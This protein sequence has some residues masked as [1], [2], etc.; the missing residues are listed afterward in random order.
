M[1]EMDQVLECKQLSAKGLGIRAISRRLGVSR[2]TVRAYLRGDRSPGIYRQE[3]RRPQ[4]V[5]DRLR[6]RVRQLL[7]EEQR[8]RTPRK[9]RL[10]GARIHRILESEDFLACPRLVRQLVQEVRMD[11]R[12][13]LQ[14][15][16][17]PLKY[18]PGEDAQV[19]F[20][21]GVVDD[22]VLGRIKVFI[23]LVRACFSGKTFAYAAPNQTR[24]ALLEGLMQAFEHFGGVFST[25][26]FDNLTPAVKKILKGRDRLLQE[27]FE[28]FCAHYGFRP[29]FCSPGKGNE[30]GGVEGCV[31]Y[32]R[33]EIL[34]PI[35]T[36]S[37]RPEVQ[38]L[39]DQWV[40]REESRIMAGRSQTIGELFS[41]EK[42]LLIPLPA[43][44]F[45]AGRVRT[46]K[47]T[48]R[49]WISLGTNFYSVPVA[50]VGREVDVRVAAEV[51]TIRF[52]DEE[53]VLHSRLHGRHQ[54]SLKI[55]HYLPLLQRKHRGL[56]R[57][58]PVKQ[59]M[60]KAA[61]CWPV[62][63]TEL[64]RREGEVLGGKSFIDTLMMCETHGT[65]AV[66]AAVEK[67]LGHPEVSVGAVRYHLWH[68]REV[69][70]PTKEPLPMAGPAVQEAH[71][72]AYMALCS[73]REVQSHE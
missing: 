58:L 38:A 67:A 39:C 40:A 13:P 48:P 17:L 24:E 70:Q 34:S 33:H 50:W 29:A 32:S 25:V 65:S 52:R 56:S 11:L 7:E 14:H 19:D 55:E 36:V 27:S 15:A 57:A 30:K 28:R 42:P 59:W 60:E 62:F 20:F 5:R 6:P 53:P 72:A 37:G 9:Q 35:P 61:P 45:E 46:A 51:V 43:H 16:Y 3:A 41:L 21:E 44:R 69:E 54:A 22:L 2:N 63:L 73:R 8:R 68:G 31:K 23:L 12:D 1:L 49:S 10:T 66:S 71:A 64:R 4:P 47:V 26:W 18:E